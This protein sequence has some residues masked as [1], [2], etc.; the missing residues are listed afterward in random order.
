MCY[1]ETQPSGCL[2]PHCPFLHNKQQPAPNNRTG[3]MQTP[4]QPGPQGPS[5]EN[6]MMSAAAV[7]QMSI[8][9]LGQGPRPGPP[10]HHTP[11]FQRPPFHPRLPPPMASHQMVRAPQYTGG[12]RFGAMPQPVAGGRGRGQAPLG[13][14]LNF[15]RGEWLF[16][17]NPTATCIQ[18]ILVRGQ[19]GVPFGL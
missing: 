6:T 14:P 7:N 3:A 19:S 12:P 16:C 4:N 18:Y 8:P 2:K 10:H 17:H 11:Q 5:Q 1:Y 9:V 13:G 15:G